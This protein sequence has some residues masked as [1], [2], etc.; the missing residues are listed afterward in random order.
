M[1]QSDTL[2]LGLRKARIGYLTSKFS[3]FCI[4][5]MGLARKDLTLMHR[6]KEQ[7]Y[8]KH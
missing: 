4:E 7:K 2:G 8:R 1:A 3:K 6:L 5:Q